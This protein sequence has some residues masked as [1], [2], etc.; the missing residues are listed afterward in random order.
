MSP[1]PTRGIKT[2]RG[3]KD[4]RSN[5]EITELRAQLASARNLGAVGGPPPHETMINQGITPGIWGH[6][7]T[8][9]LPPAGSQTQGPAIPPQQPFS[10]ESG[11]PQ[12]ATVY[13]AGPGP[14]TPAGYQQ[15]SQFNVHQLA[16]VLTS[17]LNTQASPMPPMPQQHQVQ[18]PLQVPLTSQGMYGSPY[19]LPTPCQR[20]PIPSTAPAPLAY[21]Q[22]PLQ[23]TTSAA[24]SLRDL[25]LGDVPSFPAESSDGPSSNS[26]GQSIHH[27]RGVSTP[28]TIWYGPQ[29]Q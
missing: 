19:A 18:T 24:S 26:G 16:N 17:L 20:I 4:M 21:P 1:V 29:S 6:V 14:Q 9:G 10:W 13:P 12:Q 2:P 23:P 3:E 28:G 22:G 15:H 25:S 11:T 7:P 5:Q 27:L 8:T